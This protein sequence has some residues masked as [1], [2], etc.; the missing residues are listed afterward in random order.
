MEWL[1][2]RLSLSAALIAGGMALGCGTAQ[3][4]ACGDPGKAGY[5]VDFPQAEKADIRLYANEGGDPRGRVKAAD[6]RDKIAL[7]TAKAGSFNPI[8]LH[9]NTAIELD[10]GKDKTQNN[11]YWVRNSQVRFKHKDE[12]EVTFDCERNQV[13]VSSS[14]G[15]AGGEK[16]KGAQ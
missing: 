13:K 9:Q 3:A 2:R 11:I 7:C 8:R 6:I 16:C 12:K 14:G 5:T 15:P 1:V 10:A 4:E